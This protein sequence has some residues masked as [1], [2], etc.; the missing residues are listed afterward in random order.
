VKFFGC[1]SHTSLSGDGPEVTQM[2]K[3]QPL[4]AGND[5]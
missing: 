5:T 4:H 1:F 2:M 3:I